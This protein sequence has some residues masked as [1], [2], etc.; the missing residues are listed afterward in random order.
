MSLLSAQHNFPWAHIISRGYFCNPEKVEKVKNWPVPTNPKELQPFLGLASYYSHF[1][2]K[3]TAI[4]K[5]L[6][7]LV[8]PANHQKSKKNKTN[9]EPVIDSQSNRQT[10]QWTGKH[11]EVLTY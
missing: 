9:S 4:A 2:P 1:I 10:F 7:Q 6:H 8:G 3:F 11:Q 5:C